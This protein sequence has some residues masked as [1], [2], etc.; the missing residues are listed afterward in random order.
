MQAGLSLIRIRRTR[1]PD[2][3]VRIDGHIDVDWPA[4]NRTVFD[5]RLP[6]DGVIDDQLDRFAAIR[7]RGVQR[8]QH[9]SMIIA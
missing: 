4:A 3:T 1:E 6:I 9:G 7:A 8:G 5:V 2:L